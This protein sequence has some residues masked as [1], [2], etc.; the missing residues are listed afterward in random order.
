MY[1]NRI[2]HLKEAHAALNKKIDGM[3]STGVFED[4][5]LHDLKV[6]RLHYKQEIERLESLQKSLDNSVNA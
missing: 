3:E 1:E 4:A 5:N 2:K 6:Q